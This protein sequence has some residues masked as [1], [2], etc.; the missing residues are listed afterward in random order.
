V[1]LP[2]FDALGRGTPP[3]VAAARRAEELGFDALWAG[4]H[5]I[6]HPPVLDALCALSAA[7]AVTS[8][9]EL[10]VSVL[11]LGLR[12][13]AW[14]AKQLATVEALAPG[15]LR[16]GVGVGGEYPDEF[17]AAGVSRRTR[18]RRLDEMLRTLPALLAGEAVDH[19]GPLAPVRVPGL[20]PAV[21]APLP[22]SVGGRSDASLRRAARYADQ[23]L[24]MWLGAGTV[25]TCA[26]RLA[27]L[28]A[29]QGRPVPSVALLV[30]VN[31]DDDAQAARRGA[32]ELVQG[33]YRMPLH[34]VERWTA[35]GPPEAV[36]AMLREY[37]EAGVSEFVLMPAS[38]DALGQYER[39]AKV[40]ELVRPA[41]LAGW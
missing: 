37:T 41:A 18:G 2:T 12:Q 7:A 40:R 6:S 15:R 25:R 30:L 33:Q 11:Q 17:V 3:V 1:L 36:A 34:T 27:A 35:C 21:S 14:A 39:L 32:A 9:I 24:A 28:A 20:R 38:A 13:P 8:R 10:G 26:G 22:V 29:E 5:L 4:D 23:W 19:P 31:V 16:L